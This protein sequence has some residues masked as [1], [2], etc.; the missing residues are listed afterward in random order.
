[1][2]S[3]FRNI[4]VS[5]ILRK[6]TNFR[7]IFRICMKFKSDYAWVNCPQAM[8]D[9]MELS[10]DKLNYYGLKLKE[11]CFVFVPEIVKLLFVQR[12]IYFLTEED[13]LFYNKSYL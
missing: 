9:W 3:T 13:K 7:C 2:K 12:F 5:T 1:M 11:S 10:K 6:C 4:R 8:I